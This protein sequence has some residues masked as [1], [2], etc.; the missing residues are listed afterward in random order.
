MNGY[1][2]SVDYLGN[3]REGYFKDY[4]FVNGRIIEID[5][6]NEK[7]ILDLHK[8]NDDKEQHYSGMMNKRGTVNSMNRQKRELGNT[9]S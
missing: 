5:G 3:I 9:C 8:E 7:T 6:C 1:G 4:L 2:I